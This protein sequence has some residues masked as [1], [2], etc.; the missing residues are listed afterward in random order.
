M[1]AKFSVNH[2]TDEDARL[3][4]LYAERAAAAGQ[5]LSRP[6]C[7]TT[8]PTVCGATGTWSRRTS[9]ERLDNCWIAVAELQPVVITVLE[10][11]ITVTRSVPCSEEWIHRIECAALVQ[12]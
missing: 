5:Q 3:R 12:I 9:H 7:G 4:A 10:S 2:L 6:S 8:S 1:A 11:I